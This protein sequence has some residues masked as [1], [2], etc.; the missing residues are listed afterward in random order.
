MYSTMRLE[1]LPRSAGIGEDQI[2]LTYFAYEMM[3]VLKSE[4]V[5]A[6]LLRRVHVF[7][8]VIHEKR[9]TRRH[10]CLL[11]D[12]LE[13]LGIRLE[14]PDVA[15]GD[16]SV[17]I[18]QPGVSFSQVLGMPGI[19][20]GQDEYFVILRQRC[21]KGDHFLL[22]GEDLVPDDGE[23]VDFDGEVHLILHLGKELAGIEKEVAGTATYA[24]GSDRVPVERSAP[25]AEAN[26]NDLDY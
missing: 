21:R 20:V 8:H 7:G 15:G 18:V 5:D 26:D 9:F 11:E 17:K 14:K 16:E 10:S 6:Q 25:D 4:S 13:D 1:Q 24:S 12:E 3:V 2:P 23:L 19:D 22:L